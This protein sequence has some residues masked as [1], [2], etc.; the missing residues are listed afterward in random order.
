VA[1]SDDEAESAP[2]GGSGSGGESGGEDLK[3]SAE[4]GKARKFKK[5]PKGRPFVEEEEDEEEE[6]GGDKE[7]R[8]GGETEPSALLSPHSFTYLISMIFPA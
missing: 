3:G 6:E 5:L 1:A 4:L 8:A 7:V 2:P